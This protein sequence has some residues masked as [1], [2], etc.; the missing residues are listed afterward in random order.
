[1]GN[2]S[3]GF[4]FGICLNRSDGAVWVGN[5]LPLPGISDFY[6]CNLAF[7]PVKTFDPSGEV[8]I[9]RVKYAMVA[10]LK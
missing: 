9:V 3:I 8:R 2:L 5:P 7:K 6:A 10:L 4:G 1:L